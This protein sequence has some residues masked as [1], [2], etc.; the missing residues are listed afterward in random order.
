[1]T[2]R[3]TDARMGRLRLGYGVVD[4]SICRGFTPAHHD[5]EIMRETRIGS[6]LEE[7]SIRRRVPG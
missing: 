1:M 5:I 7:M 6:Q 4:A 2:Y 3:N